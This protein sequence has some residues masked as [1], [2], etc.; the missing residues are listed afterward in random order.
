[1]PFRFEPGLVCRVGLVPA[2]AAY[3]QFFPPSI[4][5]LEIDDDLPC[6]LL[7]RSQKKDDVPSEAQ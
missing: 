5:Y 2:R 7:T 3:P 4:F 6:D 1:M